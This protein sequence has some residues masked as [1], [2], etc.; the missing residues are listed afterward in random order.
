HDPLTFLPFAGFLA[1][2]FVAQRSTRE[3]SAPHLFVALLVV[4]VAAFFWLKRYSFLPSATFL[5]FPYVLIGLSYVFFRV[6][7]LIIDSHQGALE[8]R[9][10]LISYLNYTLNFTSL[11]SG[12]IQR[13]QDYHRMEIERLPLDLVIAGRATERII[14]GY[15]KVAVVSMLLALA[16]HQAIDDLSIDQTFADRLWSGILIAAIYPVYLYFN[17]SGYVDVVIGVARFFRIEL[18]EN[19]NR[20]FSS[21]NFMVFWS[22]WHITLSNWL[23]TY[24]YNPLMMLGMERIT[25]PN[26]APYISVV[27]FFITFFLVG[28]W[29]GRTSE[30]LFFGFL[31]GGGVAANNLYQVL[32]R[33][34]MGRAGFRALSANPIYVACSRGLTFTW[35]AFTLFWFWSDWAQIRGF[36]AVLGAESLLVW[37]AIFVAAVLILAAMEAIRTACLRLTWKQHQI[38]RSRYLRTAWDT[39]LCVVTVALIGL[40]DSPAPDIVYK[41]F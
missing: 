36:V 1:L 31:Q 16:Q 26:L 40:L 12:P 28:L 8:N 25:A 33:A 21:E 24:V 6:L 19:F 32:M 30:F 18:P 13:Y 22:R 23:K 20:P 15:F 27:A 38:A 35:F 9:V 34:G 11:T 14:V 37:L 5:P 29:H 2:G 3:G 7:H 41:T 4:T 39:A 10:G 17:F